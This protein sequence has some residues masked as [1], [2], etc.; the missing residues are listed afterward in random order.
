[1]GT[2]NATGKLRVDGWAGVRHDINSI[3]ISSITTQEKQ[4]YSPSYIRKSETQR[5]PVPCWSITIMWW[6]AGSP[7]SFRAP[8][9][10]AF[11]STAPVLLALSFLQGVETIYLSKTKY[12]CPNEYYHFATPCLGEQIKL[13]LQAKPWLCFLT[14]NQLAWRTLVPADT[15]PLQAAF[16]GYLWTE[17]SR[18]VVLTVQLNDSF[19]GVECIYM[20][21][22]DRS[23][24][25]VMK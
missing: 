24:I 10:C 3:S 25:T 8:M 5:N 11:C 21:I 18:A 9:P 2:C 15:D 4:N 14:V 16:Q 20:T 12:I 7:W 19:T 17:T 22:H 6:S 1:M 13:C 23:N